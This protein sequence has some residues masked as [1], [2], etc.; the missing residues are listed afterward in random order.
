[1]FFLLLTIV[2]GATFSVFA[3]QLGSVLSPFSLLFIGELSILVAISLSFGLL[4]LA[5]ALLRI[6]PHYAL[7][8][9]GLSISVTIGLL[10]WFF[11]LEKTGAANAELIGKAE[12]LFV[13]LFSHVCFRERFTRRHLW[14][15]LLVSLGII[16]IVLR[17]VDG[18]FSLHGSD[19]LILLS[20]LLFASTTLVI[21]K[22]L[23]ALPPELL[24]FSRSLFAVVSFVL[25]SPFLPSSL[26][27]ELLHFPQTLL[28][29]L[30]GFALL[31]RFLALLG[32]YEAVERLP[33]TTI[34][35]TLPLSTVGAILF[36]HVSLGEA[37]SWHHLFGGT[38]I[39]AGVLSL[40]LSGPHPTRAHAVMHLKQHPRHHL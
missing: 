36:A 8:L 30:F 5:Q 27:S 35:L 40:A 17:D 1:M 23:S 32:F 21:K 2:G 9:L 29:I 13:L 14:T 16:V 6:G 34:Y 28:P 10:L 15:T 37:L 22:S 24:L 19:L 3:R 12:T 25:L 39:I 31:S 26:A 38:T 18:G 7:P 11:A 20:A 4:P 33:L